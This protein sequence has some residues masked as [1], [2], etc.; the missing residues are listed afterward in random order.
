[1]NE[2]VREERDERQETREAETDAKVT[3]VGANESSGTRQVGKMHT[4][5][6]VYSN[7]LCR[8]VESAGA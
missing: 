5:D 4:I 7:R 3:S 8:S 6:A 1:M 2:D